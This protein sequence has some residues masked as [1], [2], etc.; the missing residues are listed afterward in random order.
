MLLTI[1]SQGA[2]EQRRFVNHRLLPEEKG[3]GLKFNVFAQSFKTLAYQRGYERTHTEHKGK[4]KHIIAD[5]TKLIRFDFH[6]MI[7]I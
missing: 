7:P 3:I 5:K 6:S 4:H 1:M 2:R